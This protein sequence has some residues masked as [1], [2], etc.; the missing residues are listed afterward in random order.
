MLISGRFTQ[1]LLNIGKWIQE[2]KKF[3]YVAPDYIV[4]GLSRKE[5]DNIFPPQKPKQED[6]LVIDEVR[7]V[8]WEETEK[9]LTKIV[10]KKI[11]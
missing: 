6:Q 4:I 8:D 1:Q 2:R 7:T 10:A 9:L 3:M 11:N 5:Y